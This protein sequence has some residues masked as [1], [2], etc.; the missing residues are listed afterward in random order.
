MFV[1]ASTI[2]IGTSSP[3]AAGLSK[4]NGLC[5]CSVDA[6]VCFDTS[7]SSSVL[8]LQLLFPAICCPYFLRIGNVCIK[9]VKRF[10]D[11][12]SCW[13]FV[14]RD[15]A[16]GLPDPDEG[17]GSLTYKSPASTYSDQPGM[18]MAERVRF[19]CDSVV[20]A[21]RIRVGYPPL[22]DRSVGCTNRGCATRNM[23]RQWQARIRQSSDPQ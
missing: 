15:C 11:D 20:T 10:Y 14:A 12:S 4:T 19:L 5:V 13:H 21:L 23:V 3:A 22:K 16:P 17:S 2:A 7:I 18:I 9:D 8:A 6:I 1:A